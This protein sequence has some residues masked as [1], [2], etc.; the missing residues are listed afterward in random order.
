MP[1]LAILPDHAF[2]DRI[3]ATIA[4]DLI[5]AALLQQLKPGGRMVFLARLEDDQ[6][7]LLVTK[8]ESGRFDIE[9]ILPVRFSQLM[10]GAEE[11]GADG[12]RRAP[13]ASSTMLTG[14]AGRP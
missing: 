7:L 2:F 3:I 14:V 8:D 1:D 13:S 6:R 11:A 9:E 12:A 4:P 10:R 5:P